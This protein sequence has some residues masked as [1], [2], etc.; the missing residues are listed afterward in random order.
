MLLDR[1][2]PA[3]GRAPAN[4]WFTIGAFSAFSLAV[5]DVAIFVAADP[6][7]R[8]ERPWLPAVVLAQNAVLA[9]AALTGFTNAWRLR[10]P[11]P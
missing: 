4:A 3:P 6:A 1:L 8:A 10:Y 11:R 9:Y 7:L 5:T 2:I